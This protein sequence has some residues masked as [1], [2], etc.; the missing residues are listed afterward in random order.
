MTGR[1]VPEWIGSTPDAKIP[2]RVRARVFLAHD[3]RCHRTGRKI[4]P[5]EAWD[6]DHVI[7][8]CNGGEHREGNLAPILSGKPH[9]KKTAEDV[10]IKSKTA[11]IR[12]KHLGLAKP[13]HPMPGSRQSKWKRKM[14]GE[15]VLR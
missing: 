7:A 13:R 5:G 3:G 10:A 11:G 14:T 8:L 9:K 12:N 1:S 6:L 15:V 2:A 4:A